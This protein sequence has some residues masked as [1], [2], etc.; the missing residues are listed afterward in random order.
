MKTYI[1]H[2]LK[3]NKW[4]YEKCTR[5]N[6]KYYNKKKEKIDNENIFN[7]EWQKVKQIKIHN[8]NLIAL[9]NVNNILLMDATGIFKPVSTK[10]LF[11]VIK[12]DRNN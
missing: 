5:I 12:D 3:K 7:V 9:D 4:F 10:D 1:V 6:G 8:K 2:Y 11:K